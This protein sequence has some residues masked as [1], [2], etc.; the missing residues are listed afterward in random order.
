MIIVKGKLGD[1]KKVRKRIPI[2]L[3]PSPQEEKKRSQ[4][5]HL[6]LGHWLGWIFIVLVIIFGLG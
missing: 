2:F 4:W 3:S 6:G 5:V 1:K